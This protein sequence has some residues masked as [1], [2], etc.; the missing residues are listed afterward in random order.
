[1]DVSFSVL[2]PF[3]FDW[4]NCAQAVWWGSIRMLVLYSLPLG[5]MVQLL[6]LLMCIALCTF[7]FSHFPPSLLTPLI[8]LSIFILH[9]KTSTY[10][11]FCIIISLFSTTWPVYTYLY[12]TSLYLTS[13]HIPSH[14]HLLDSSLFFQH[15]PSPHSLKLYTLHSSILPTFLLLLLL[16]LPS[17]LSHTCNICHH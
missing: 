17:H 3:I 5:I 12:P 10:L 11:F 15:Y 8:F 9:S 1:M 13:Q 2:T 14:L 4:T 7:H 6:D 16:L